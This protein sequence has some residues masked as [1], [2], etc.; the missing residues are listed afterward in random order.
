MSERTILVNGRQEQVAAKTTV[1]ALLEVHGLRS[2]WVVVERNGD[3]LIRS[4]YPEIELEE[5]DRV[6]IVRAVAGGSR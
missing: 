5:G 6:E 4:L 3:A 1:E 2:E